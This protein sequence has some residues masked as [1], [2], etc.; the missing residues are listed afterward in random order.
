M[1]CV[2]L[3][4]RNRIT[5][6]VL[7]CTNATESKFHPV[8]FKSSPGIWRTPIIFWREWS[9]YPFSCRMSTLGGPQVRVIRTL[10]WAT[11]IGIASLLSKCNYSSY[12]AMWTLFFWEPII[13]PRGSNAGCSNIQAG[14]HMQVPVVIVDTLRD[15][16]NNVSAN[17]WQFENTGF[18]GN[19]VS[20]LCFSLFPRI[21]IIVNTFSPCD[22][23]Q[24]NWLSER[25]SPLVLDLQ[26]GTRL[27]T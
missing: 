10:S 11:K 2:C 22:Y 8:G 14:A 12:P 18:S 1:L 13:A 16:T 6:G 21:S 9:K 25:H 19:K 20:G 5:A 15:V 27:S 7:G 23:S 17:T 3:I 26:K 4:K 24:H